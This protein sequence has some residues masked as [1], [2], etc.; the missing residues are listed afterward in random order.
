MR[1]FL[2]VLVLI[3]IICNPNEDGKKFELGKGN[4]RKKFNTN[5]YECIVKNETTS[6]DLKKN[7]EEH[8]NGELRKTLFNLK[9]KLSESDQE[10]VKHCRKE[11]FMKFREDI[12]QTFNELSSMSSRK[13]N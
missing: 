6:E 5:L 2:L 12:Q 7:V 13:H 10:I 4:K 3:G 8:K 1:N 9:D 11:S